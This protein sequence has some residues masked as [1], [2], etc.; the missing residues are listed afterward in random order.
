MYIY[1]SKYAYDW[2]IIHNLEEDGYNDAPH[3]KMHE[4]SVCFF[5]FMQLFSFFD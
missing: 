4:D 3:L 1:N 2:K 5:A